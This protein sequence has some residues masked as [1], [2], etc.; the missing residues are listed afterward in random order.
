M[1]DSILVRAAQRLAGL[2][3]AI[4]VAAPRP[5]A[6][7]DVC[8]QTLGD[9]IDGLHQA[10]V[11][12]SDAT[13]TL[14]LV[15]QTYAWNGSEDLVLVNRLNLLGGY[16]A[17][18]SARTV[19]PSNTVIDGLGDLEITMHQAGL[20]LT[21][22]GIRFHETEFLNVLATQTCL[23]YGE[24]VTWR[25]SIVDTT[26][27]DF[28]IGNSCGDLLVQNN[29]L[30]VRYGTVLSLSPNALA[31]DA[32]IVNN[33]LIDASDGNGLELF[34]APDSETATFNVSNNIIWG[35]AGV[36]FVLRGGSAQPI[37]RAYH[38][39]WGSVT[40]PLQDSQEN[41]SV[42]PQLDAN[43]RPI[44]PSSPAIN[45]G[46]NAP[47][48]GLPAVD[49][50]G[51]PR[52]IGSAVDRGAYE[53]AI[54]DITELVV[55][56]SSDSGPGSLRQAILDANSLP[57]TNTIRF[58]IPGDFG[59]ILLPAT[60]YP[61]IVTSMR[62]DAFTQPGAA[63][64]ASPWSNAADYRIS[65]A[66]GTTTS[67]AFR[68]PVGAGANVKL[69]LSGFIIGGFTN[70]VLL[71][72][73]SDHVIRGNHFG[74]YSDGFL[75]GSDNVNGI[76]V[77]STATNVHIGGIDPA[78]RN[79][80]SGH[81]EPPS[82]NGFGIYIGGSG[83]GHLVIGNLVGTYPDGNTAHGNRVGIRLDTDVSVL[84]QNLVSGNDTAIDLRGSENIV[85]T[86]RIG[87]KA[88][89]ICLPPCTPDTALPNTNGLLVAAGAN[90]NG[91]WQNQIANSEYA[92]M[93]VF[94]GA[95]NNELR[96]NRV[97]AS[98]QF[99]VDTRDPSG[100]NPIDYDGPP[101]LPGG[102]EN[103]NCDQNFPELAGAFGGAYAGRVT[104]SLSTWNGVHRLEFFAG[105]ECGPGGQGGARRFLGSHDIDVDGASLFPPHNGLALFDLAIE[106]PASLHG[107]FITATATSADGDSSEYS[108]CVEYLCDQI[109]AH[110]FDGPTAQTCSAP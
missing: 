60:P 86:N 55:T 83:S 53:S 17:D 35:S 81:Q 82:G 11:F 64:N 10:T 67:Y 21:V 47:P 102:C 110:G 100:M 48:G 95:V 28:R 84:L 71:Q 101:I 24:E 18:C 33:T 14:R 5:A 79:S 69:E 61:D 15:A 62:I 70:A 7:L 93:I 80:I 52:V 27:G 2:V 6:A 94:A 16:N 105:P 43:G 44:P 107:Q 75:G 1:A 78:D 22:E 68:V 42:D 4:L 20:G 37:V 109:F 108:A 85:A 13:V 40:V 25:R 9:L 92:G 98:Q 76:Y 56:N 51:N 73:G 19:N 49:I 39:I 34:R 29:L 99:D 89:Y 26:S 66:G 32:Y 31:A 58:A 41:F 87:V 63:P 3:L 8:V 97:Y 50:E 12:Q 36:D 106:S 30:R 54:V 96:A 72:S 45:S 65:I 74:S 59:A 46:D 91:I 104:G 38:N 90:G 23:D 77:N 88:F 103:A 57:D